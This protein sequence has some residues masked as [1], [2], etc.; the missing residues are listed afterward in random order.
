MEGAVKLLN[1]S[2]KKENR[3]PVAVILGAVVIAS[4]ILF[5]NNQP[6]NYKVPA[7]KSYTYPGNIPIYS[8]PDGYTVAGRWCFLLEE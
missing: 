8:C 6:D 3:I 2:L 7:N 5:S 1:N 4:A